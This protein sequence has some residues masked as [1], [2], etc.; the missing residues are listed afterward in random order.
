MSVV[1]KQIMSER[2]KVAQL[3]QLEPGQRKLV[4]AQG[5]EI[6]LFNIKGTVYALNNSCPHSTGPLIEGRLHQTTLTCPWH[7]AR[8]NVTTGQCLGGPATTDASAY[9]VMI[10]GDNIFLEVD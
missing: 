4:R 9:T 2:I 8:F 3:S 10:D 6:A 5:Q 7:G 1:S